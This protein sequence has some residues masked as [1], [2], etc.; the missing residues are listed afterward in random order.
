MKKLPLL[1]YFT[2]YSLIAF[3]FTGVSLLLFINSHMVNSQIITME[4]I[5]HLALDYIVEPE[6]SINDYKTT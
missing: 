1:R 4:H 6:L 2:F 5:T 3:T